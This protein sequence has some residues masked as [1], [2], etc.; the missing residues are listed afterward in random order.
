MFV[1]EELE[2]LGRLELDASGR[3]FVQ[4]R[5]HPLPQGSM[6]HGVVTDGV[7]HVMGIAKNSREM[8]QS[9]PKGVESAPSSTSGLTRIYLGFARAVK[10]LQE[11]DFDAKTL[12]RPALD[13]D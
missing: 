4:V 9:T 3:E 1:L 7:F 12:K 10:W 8:G 13:L 5:R 6:L 2:E 11:E